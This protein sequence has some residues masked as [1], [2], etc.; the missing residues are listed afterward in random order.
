MLHATRYIVTSGS[1]SSAGVI[2][3]IAGAGAKYSEIYWGAALHFG[4]CSH[5]TDMDYESR[6][7][8]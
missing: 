5:V 7:H 8:V 6:R 3:L 1:L 2:V 4:K